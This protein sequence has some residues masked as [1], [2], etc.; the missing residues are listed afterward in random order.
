MEVTEIK[1]QMLSTLLAHFYICR[2]CKTVDTDRERCHVGHP[3]NK[4]GEPSPGGQFYF[5]V[6]VLAMINLM[7]EQYHL[8]PAPDESEEPN[9]LATHQIAIIIFFCTLWE[10]LLENF[11][12][13][14][15]DHNKIPT[16]VSERLM[17][18]HK[19]REG[20][21]NKLFPSLVDE[22]WSTV[23][24]ELS[25]ASEL[26]YKETEKFY[27][28]VSETRN[29]F[30]HTGNIWVILPELPEKCLNNIW[31]SVNLFISLHNRFIAK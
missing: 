8:G 11:L 18:D 31:P 10:A 30:I 6:S 25:N 2:F 20:R 23:V 28:E 16:G 14:L 3:C 19:F 17:K 1:N 4:C 29:K 27:L 9:E 13:N 22:K 5:P 26:N 15:L 12:T 21:V 7:Q 24:K